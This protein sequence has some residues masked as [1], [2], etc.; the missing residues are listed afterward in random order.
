MIY[1]SYYSCPVCGHLL[2]SLGTSELRNGKPLQKCPNCKGKFPFESFGTA[3]RSVRGFFCK[4]CRFYLHDLAMNWL[5]EGD[6]LCFKCHNVVAF[7]HPKLGKIPEGVIGTPTKDVLRRSIHIEGDS[8][9]IEV[10]RD[11]DSVVLRYLN[12]RA[13]REN[14]E[15][16]RVNRSNGLILLRPGK[17]LGYLS[18]DKA[19]GEIPTIRQLF[20]DSAER[21][22]GN[23]Q[24]LLKYFDSK[25]AIKSSTDGLRFLVESPNEASFELFKKLGYADGRCA[26]THG[27]L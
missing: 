16:L 5:A 3:R 11:W 15:F 7:G 2:E 1:Y 8:S 17:Y 22:R 24:R 12:S 25:I 14:K 9:I 26:F 19:E 4:R 23:A 10:S 6:I 18:W 21:R 13:Q 27:P 20:V